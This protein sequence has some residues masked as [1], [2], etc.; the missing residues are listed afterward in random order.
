MNEVNGEFSV[1]RLQALVSEALEDLKAVDPVV[2]DVHDKTSITD[3]MVIVSGNSNRHVRSI[4]NSVVQKAKDSGIRPQGV[5]GEEGGEW[6]LVDLGDVV[7]HVMQPEVRDLYR[8]ERIWGVDDEASDYP[9]SGATS[10]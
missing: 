9:S 3:V 1:E 10:H 5:E 6:I 2:L 8:L 7:V 4:A